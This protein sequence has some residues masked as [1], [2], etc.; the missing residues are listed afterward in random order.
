ML[1]QGMEDAILI[2]SNL[3][4][5]CL[6]PEFS[7]PQQ[8]HLIPNMTLLPRFFPSSEHEGPPPPE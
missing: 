8:S 2:I 6:K 4:P 1:T 3:S 5:P 7:Y